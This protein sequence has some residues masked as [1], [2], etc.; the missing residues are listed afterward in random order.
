MNIS[1]EHARAD[2]CNFDGSF[3]DET[4]LLP[5]LA[6]CCVILTERAGGKQ[7]LSGEI[8]L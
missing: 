5:G 2:E 8:A 4:R 6:L 7:C 3:H 1:A